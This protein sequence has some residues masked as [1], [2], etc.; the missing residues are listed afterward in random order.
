MS[1]LVRTFQRNTR[2]RDF[3][4]G[5]IHGHF[6]R[7][8]TALREVDFD[9]SVDRLFSVGDLVDRGPESSR[10]LD[11]LKQ[12]WLFAVRG[13]HEDM[14]IRHPN[15]HRDTEAY[16]NNGGG[17]FIDSPIEFQLEVATALSALP[18]AIS[19]NTLAGKFGIVHADCPTPSWDEFTRQLEDP[20]LSKTE[21]KRLLGGALWSRERIEWDDQ[22]LVRDVA[23]VIVG[24]T[25]VPRSRCIGNVHYT[26]TGVCYPKLNKLTL[27][28]VSPDAETVIREAATT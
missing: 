14:A 11:Y 23:A 21:L 1:T 25:P 22:R 12:P 24:H 3:V 9:R 13:N 20:L 19:I 6:A 15:G 28:Q 18:I 17:W 27:F 7:L 10:V 16:R 2:G 26:D 8:D 5:D 4:V